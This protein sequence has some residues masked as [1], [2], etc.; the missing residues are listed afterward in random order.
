MVVVLRDGTPP[1]L[2]PSDIREPHL[3]RFLRW[4][5]LRPGPGRRG[6]LLGRGDFPSRVACRNRDIM[7][8]VPLG[9]GS[10]S[11]IFV[12][13]KPRPVLDLSSLN[14]FIILTPFKME[15]L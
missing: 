11:R 3:L 15:P 6:P 12:V 10:Y 7:S 2:F 13:Q 1:V 4:R 8:R 14:K 9:P 5:R